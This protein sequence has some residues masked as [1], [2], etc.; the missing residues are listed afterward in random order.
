MWRGA[1]GVEE[2][3]EIW[4]GASGLGE[5]GRAGKE[6]GE[7]GWMVNRAL[8]TSLKK[9]TDSFSPAPYSLPTSCSTCTVACLAAETRRKIV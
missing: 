4:G 6:R 8:P 3:K 5:G 9:K 7:V 1:G 2:K